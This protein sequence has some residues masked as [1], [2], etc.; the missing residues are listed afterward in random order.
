MKKLLIAF[1]FFAGL[2]F[3]SASVAVVAEATV[4]GDAVLSSLDPSS[5][6]AG[7]VVTVT[8]SNLGGSPALFVTRSGETTPISNFIAHGDTFN[9]ETQFI[10]TIPPVVSGLYGLVAKNQVVVGQWVGAS[11][12]LPFTIA[13]GLVA[14][15]LT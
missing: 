1:S 6:P 8:G 12:S 14:P 13:P 7:T 4:T 3:L 15:T 5:A 11:N 2:V 9:N 10:F